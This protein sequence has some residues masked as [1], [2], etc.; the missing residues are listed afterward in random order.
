[1]EHISFDRVEKLAAQAEEVLDEAAGVKQIV[2]EFQDKVGPVA[3][4]STES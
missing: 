3:Q 2:K 4:S 1:M